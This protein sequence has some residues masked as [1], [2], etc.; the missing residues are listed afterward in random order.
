MKIFE[1]IICTF[2]TVKNYLSLV[3]YKNFISKYSKWNWTSGIT[4]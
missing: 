1:E 4:D 2:S 3:L